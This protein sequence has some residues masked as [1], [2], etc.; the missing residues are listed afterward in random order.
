LTDPAKSLA[1]IVQKFFGLVLAVFPLAFVSGA[2]LIPIADGTTWL[3]EMTQ[4]T[5]KEFT[6][7]DAK[8]GPDGKVHALAAYRLTGTQY[9]DGK[10]FLKFEMHRDGVITNSDLMTVDEYG[11]FCAARI[12]QYGDVTKLDPAQTMI[13]V[14]LK[15]GASWEFN[16]KLGDVDVRQ[17]YDVVGEE[18]LDLPAGKFH[19][20]H[21]HGEQTAPVRMTIDRW[22]VNEVGI[23]KDVTE[24]KMADGHVLRR[25]SL[26]LKEKPKI[27]PRPE[28]KSVQPTKKFSASLGKGPIGEATSKFGSDTPKIYARW[29]GHNLRNQAKIRAVW[30]AE[31]I[32]DIAAPNYKIDEASTTANA[33]D[34]HGIFTLAKPDEGWAPG[35]YRVEFYVDD[36]LVETV[37][38]KI[39][40]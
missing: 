39:T 18:D 40:K 15:T 36:E 14:P 5:G 12:D 7:S 23:V 34:S 29:Q 27:A 20:F 24:T 19:A 11:I 28:V 32:G 31:N 25:I 37:K 1:S 22:F 38:L 10:N 13:A 17:H 8:V 2:S 9:V 33:R 16:G 6:L 3:Y 4:E 35:D 21:I 30:I 26:E